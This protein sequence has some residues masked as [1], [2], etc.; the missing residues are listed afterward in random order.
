MK[1]NKPV[2]S[3]VA[4]CFVVLLLLT[5]CSK[6]KAEPDHPRLT[7][8]VALRDVTFHSA[9]LNRDMQYRVILPASIARGEKLPVIYLLHGGG[10]GFHDWSNYSDVAC[11]AEHN[12]ILVMPEGNSS[13][14]T[15]SAERPQDRYED[16]IVNDL[17]TDVESKFPV[18]AG[19]NNRAIVGVSMGGFGAVKLALRYPELFVFAAGISPAVDVP[20]LPFS[21]KRIQQWRFHSS[22]FG[23][24]GS[25]T[26]HDNDP[27]VLA[28]S[29]DPAKM[30]YLFLTCG[31][32][33]GLPPS[34]RAF[35]AL[36]AK[37]QF[38]YE[39]HTTPGDHNW[40]QC[41][42]WLP[43]VFRSL[44]EHVNPKG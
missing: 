12:V 35:A 25:Q 17:I 29:A 10:G 21:I 33:E 31:E 42:E 39:F 28:R 37:R 44:F 19:R 6:K 38:Q 18:A 9:A 22:I 43:S 3:A 24:W 4:L 34:N 40:N 20:S 15:N 16:Y 1:A 11:Y 2:R 8:K 27:F 13:Y 7:P 30:P 36:L 26:R 14:Y 23:P 5:A 32:Q 41:E